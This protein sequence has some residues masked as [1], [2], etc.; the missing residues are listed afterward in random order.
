MKF[1][2]KPHWP[3]QAKSIALHLIITYTGVHSLVTAIRH[4]MLTTSHVRL[5]GQSGCS[6][7][8]LL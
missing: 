4:T 3:P 5:P 2:V 6:L 8:S 7:S 1:L